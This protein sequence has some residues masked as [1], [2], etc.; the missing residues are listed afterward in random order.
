MANGDIVYTA[1]AGLLVLIYSAIHLRSPLLALFGMLQTGLAFPLAYF[2]FRLV[3]QISFYTTLHNL[4][5][6]VILGVAAD[7]MFVFAEAWR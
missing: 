2:F 3:F 4:S 6:F 7:D 5:V 1:L